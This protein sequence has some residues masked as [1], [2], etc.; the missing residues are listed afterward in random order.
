[1]LLPFDS[2]YS[3]SIKEAIASAGVVNKNVY[4]VKLMLTSSINLDVDGTV[5]VN[6]KRGTAGTNYQGHVTGSDYAIFELAASSKINVKG[7]G[8]LTSIGFVIGDG[9]VEA[10]SNSNVVDTMFIESFR[11]I[12][13]ASCSERV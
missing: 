7:G 9:L 13:R 8:K 10:Y 1:M 5:I 6:A 12:G 3:D 11:E 4:F 2:N